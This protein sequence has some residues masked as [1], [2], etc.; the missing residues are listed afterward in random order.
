MS[1]ILLSFFL[2]HLSSFAASQWCK[3]K[4]HPL[5]WFD[6]ALCTQKHVILFSKEKKKK[7]KT[8]CTYLALCEPGFR[9]RLLR[10]WYNPDYSRFGGA[11][12]K[13][14]REKGRALFMQPIPPADIKQD[15]GWK[16]ACPPTVSPPFKGPC[17]LSFSLSP[18]FAKSFA[19][20]FSSKRRDQEN[21]ICWGP[22]DC[23]AWGRERCHRKGKTAR[24]ESEK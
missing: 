14:I 22:H 8:E 11:E 12:V 21:K 23:D 2:R 15:L 18:P 24:E 20:S 16:I 6:V 1:F 3:E 9:W 17:D 4:P 7:R 10:S 19:E 13:E 5:L